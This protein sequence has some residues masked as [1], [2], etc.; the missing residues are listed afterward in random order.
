MR[1]KLPYAQ[2]ICAK[3]TKQTRVYSGN[4][5]QLLPPDQSINPIIRYEREMSAKEKG[6]TAQGFDSAP[7]R[8]IIYEIDT[9]HGTIGEDG[10]PAPVHHMYALRWD[11]TKIDVDEE[12][13]QTLRENGYKLNF[14]K[15]ITL[16]VADVRGF[17]RGA[18]Q[19]SPVYPAPKGWSLRDKL[20]DFRAKILIDL[21]VK[22]VYRTSV[23]VHTLNNMYPVLLA[24]LDVGLT[25]DEQAMLDA[26][27]DL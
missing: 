19:F 26:I 5:N 2:F 25:P 6:Y 4:S 20:R 17:E 15:E 13:D 22:K 8:K 21:S 10:L 7:F 3:A 18:P 24:K 14:Y 23:W 16:I 1:N 9:M 11:G 27:R 12:I